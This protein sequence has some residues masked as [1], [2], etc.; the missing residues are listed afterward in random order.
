MNINYKYKLVLPGS[1]NGKLVTRTDIAPINSLEIEYPSFVRSSTPNPENWD[2]I[3]VTLTDENGNTINV[4]LKD[5]EIKT[6]TLSSGQS[7]WDLG[8]TIVLSEIPE[9]CNEACPKIDPNEPSCEEVALNIQSNTT[10]EADPIQDISVNAHSITKVGDA[11]HSS[12]ETI[13]G[14][15]SLYFDGNGDH[16]KN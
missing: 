3:D 8:A 10:N 2:I 12:T 6:A 9:D 16:L 1:D 14:E 13:L 7:G 4:E 11:K 15:S 5:K